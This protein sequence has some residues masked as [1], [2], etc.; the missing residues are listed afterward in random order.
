MAVKT[1]TRDRAFTLHTYGAGDDITLGREAARQLIATKGVLVAAN[2][3]LHAPN[4]A[5]SPQFYEG[6]RQHLLSLPL[7][8]RRI[9]QQVYR[10]AGRTL[11]A[12]SG[13]TPQDQLERVDQM[14]LGTVLAICIGTVF[15]LFVLGM[16]QITFRN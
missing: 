12:P 14:P 2:R 4:R 1:V 5:Y 6:M 8:E 13:A 16:F 7:A 11:A 9:A 15:V 3:S 10:R